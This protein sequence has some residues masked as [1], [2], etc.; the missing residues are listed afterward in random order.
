MENFIKILEVTL[1]WPVAVLVIFVIFFVKFNV[2][3]EAFLKNIKSIKT[4]W[5]G[6]V[7][8]QTQTQTISN[9]AEKEKGRYISP[10]E[11]KKLEEGIRNLLERDQLTLSQKEKLEQEVEKAYNSVRHWKFTYLNIFFI[12]ITKQVLNWAATIKNFDKQFYH[13]VWSLTIPE[14]SNRNVILDVLT[15]NFML[16][17]L[18]GINY[19]ITSHGYEFLQFIGYIPPKPNP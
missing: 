9:D 15:S 8:T 16:E 7:Q 4:P 12:P 3:I 14:E 6:E 17:T 13:I 5:G 2:A 1:S 10:E 18:D 11:E 19:K